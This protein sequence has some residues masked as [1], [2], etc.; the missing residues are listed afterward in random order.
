MEPMTAALIVF[1]LALLA[2]T[3]CLV[4]ALLIVTRTEQGYRASLE[5]MTI[6]VDQ[7]RKEHAESIQREATVRETELNM[8]KKRLNDTLE[9]LMGVARG[10]L[11]VAGSPPVAGPFPGNQQWSGSKGNGLPRQQPVHPHQPGAPPTLTPADG[12][13]RRGA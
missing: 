9:L 7:L 4:L 5:A 1:G 8:A 3:G 10:S 11:G 6:W 2:G 13:E 12:L